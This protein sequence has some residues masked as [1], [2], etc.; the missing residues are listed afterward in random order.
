MEVT[1][2][3]NTQLLHIFSNRLKWYLA[4]Q[5]PLILFDSIY[6]CHITLKGHVLLLHADL[7]LNLQKAH[8]LLFN[9]VTVIFPA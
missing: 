3:F 8:H 1:S 4:M 2:A 7:K 5:I 9:T 6:I